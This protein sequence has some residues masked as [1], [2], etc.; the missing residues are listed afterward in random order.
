MGHQDFSGFFRGNGPFLLHSA[1]K[2]SQASPQARRPGLC[3]GILSWL[4]T[5]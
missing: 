4:L 3:L 2:P 1:S 5:S